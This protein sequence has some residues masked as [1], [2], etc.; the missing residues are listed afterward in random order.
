MLARILRI[1][2]VACFACSAAPVLAQ[3]YPTKPIRIIVPT[4][5]GGGIDIA[6]RIITPK[7]GEALGRPVLLEYHPGADT[8]LG[9]GLAARAAPDGY[10]LLG[11]FDNFPITPHLVKKV[12]YDAV[13]DFAPIAMIIRGP[14]ILAVPPQLGIKELNELLALAKSKAGKFNYAS[15]GAGT[16]SHLTAELFKSATAID[17][18]PVHYKGAAPALT[19]LMGG[20]VHFMIVAAG[21]VLPQVKSGRLV[22]L[23]VTAT[24][25]AAQLPG[26][27]AIAESYP[28]FE[29]QSWIGMLAPA[30]TPNEI[31]RRVNAEV[32]KALADPDVKARFEERGVEVV[33][34]TPEAFAQWIAEQSQKWG[35][36]I[37]ERKITLD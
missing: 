13:R 15:A 21:T 20:H 5:P 24:K 32:V 35:R 3:S 36:V 2:L 22:P 8:T 37:R 6:M 18:Q 17:A 4:P 16:S 1:V 31:L 30:G 26:V 28:G 10:T 29:A 14:M 23:G 34:D 27:P 7:L 19:D 11:V 9:T 33:G 12:P 25:R